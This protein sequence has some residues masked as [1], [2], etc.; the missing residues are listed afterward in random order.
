MNKSTFQWLCVAFVCAILSTSPVFSQDAKNYSNLNGGTQ[1]ATDVTATL[2]DMSSGTTQLI[3]ANQTDVSSSVVAF[4]FEVW[5]MGQRFTDFSVNTN[6]VL[7]FGTTAV[8]NE[9]NTHAI[10]TNAYRISP[11]SSAETVGVESPVT[12][13]FKTSNTTGKVHYKLL[14][15]SP[16]RRMVV[17]WKDILFNHRSSSTDY[18][19]FQAHIYETTPLTGTS[20]EG[21]KIYFVYGE[22]P[23]D[24]QDS[25]NNPVDA[26]VHLGIGAGIAANNYLGLQLNSGVSDPTPNITDNDLTANS[27]NYVNLIAKGNNITLLHSTATN[28]RRFINLEVDEVT[29]LPTDFR[30]ICITDTKI[31]LTWINPASTNAVGAVIYRSTDNVNFAF[32]GQVPLGTTLYSDSGLTPGQTYYYRLYLVNEGKLSKLGGTATVNAT[33][34]ATAHYSVV[35]GNWSDPATWSKGSVPTAADDVVINCSDKVYVDANATCKNITMLVTATLRFANGGHTLTVINDL[36][37]EG[38]VDMNGSNAQLTVGGN[39]TNSNSWM[40]GSS[41]TVTLNGSNTQTLTNTGTSTIVNASTTLTPFAFDT[42]IPD[43]TVDFGTNCTKASS[44]LSLKSALKIV[45]GYVNTYNVLTEVKVNITHPANDELEIW[46][47][48]SGSATLYQLSSDNGGSG[49]NYNNVTFT[50]YATNAISDYAGVNRS[51]SNESLR[52]ECQ[53][54]STISSAVSGVWAMY[55]NDDD[56]TNG[57]GIFKSISLSFEARTV[58]NDFAFHHLIINN[59]STTGVV[60]ANNIRVNGSLTLTDGIIQAGANEVIFNDDATTSNGSNNS[61]IHGVARKIG[62]DA[63][64]F[65][66]GDNDPLK[67]KDHLA[68]IAISAPSNVTDEFTAQYFYIDPASTAYDPNTKDD[69]N[70]TKI[71][72]CEYWI[73]NR[74]AGTSN[75]TVSLSYENIR[76]CGVGNSADLRIA[77]WDAGSTRWESE[78]NGGDVTVGAFNGIVTAAAVTNFSP[79]TLATQDPIGTPLPTTLLDFDV[80]RGKEGIFAQWKVLD[81][82]DVAYYQLQRSADGQSFID[83]GKKTMLSESPANIKQYSVWDTEPDNKTNATL[84]YRLKVVDKNGSYAYSPTEALSFKMSYRIISTAPNPFQNKFT[85]SY[86]VPFEQTVVFE[87]RDLLGHVIHTYRQKA[88]LGINQITLDKLINLPKGSYLLVLEHKNGKL[89]RTV[90]K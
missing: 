37:N 83:A 79:F 14:G 49:A 1:F 78:G 9:A 51:F 90:L 68:N 76:S 8:H 50:D 48:P 57:T 41:A 26:D 85:I 29:N 87:L 62:N 86:M 34:G 19:T 30:E 58:V 7:Q 20:T 31:D 2:E 89:T 59:T 38:I 23:S 36:N 72:N 70:L 32:Q 52:P 80:N 61:Y 63:F 77:R 82:K 21:G 45:T 35:S 65:P 12:G 53:E 67:N 24:F 46:I 84:Y 54:L 33:T 16:N 43:N 27:A 42:S 60:L 73:L 44:D 25:G 22:M 81:D 55:V 10:S 5:F 3:G 6:G 75:V 11:M 74:E 56:A 64:T 4:G 18:A 40:S 39:I 28:S 17:E 15:T 69:V 71:S 66:V 13:S 47:G 88:S